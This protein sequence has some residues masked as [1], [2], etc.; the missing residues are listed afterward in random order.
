MGIPIFNYFYHI[1]FNKYK[2]KNLNQIN[3]NTTMN[4]PLILIIEKKLMDKIF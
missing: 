1:N 2:K 4:F 3:N